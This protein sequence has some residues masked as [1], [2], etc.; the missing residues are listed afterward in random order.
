MQYQGNVHNQQFTPQL[1]VSPEDRFFINQTPYMALP[2][3][4][5]RAAQLPINPHPENMTAPSLCDIPP[6]P[7]SDDDIP[8]RIS[9]IPIATDQ[10]HPKGAGGKK[11][12]KLEN[13]RQNTQ[14]KGE[15]PDQDKGGKVKP[16]RKKK[17]EAK[18]EKAEK[19]GGRATGSKNFSIDEMVELVKIVAE[20][21]PI[22][23]HKWDAVANKYNSL[24]AVVNEKWMMRDSRSC[25][26]KFDQV[27]S[28][29]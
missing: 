10:Y 25:R 20:K 4:Q 15:R 3:R 22:G 18:E 21:L 14:K 16:K 28:I 7:S 5:R 23:G 1:M 8:E 12:Q 2:P 13:S 9:A 17:E 11:A 6:L 27:K 24:D 26:N 29:C 19:R